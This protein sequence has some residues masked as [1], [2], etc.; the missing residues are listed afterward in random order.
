MFY[1]MFSGGETDTLL[2]INDFLTSHVTGTEY[3]NVHQADH[4]SHIICKF[5]GHQH[6]LR[7]VTDLPP[8]T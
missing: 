5:L 3:Q 2:V 6:M 7:D 8:I 1:V 4:R